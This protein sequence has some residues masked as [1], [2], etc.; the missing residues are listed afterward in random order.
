MYMHTEVLVLHFQLMF[1]D[2][3]HPVIQLIRSNPGYTSEA[4]C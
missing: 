4:S 3:H 2:Q 1:Q